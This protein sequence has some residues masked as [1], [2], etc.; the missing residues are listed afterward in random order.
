[1]RCRLHVRNVDLLGSVHFYSS[2]LRNLHLTPSSYPIRHAIF[3]GHLFWIYSYRLHRQ[4]V[5]IEIF[6]ITCQSYAVPSFRTMSSVL[7]STGRPGFGSSLI[8][9]LTHRK[10]LN[11]ILLEHKEHL[12]ILSGIAFRLLLSVD[13]N[14]NNLR[15]LT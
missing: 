12:S 3:A 11:Q 4:V 6:T 10:G 13:R 1:M 7:A 9:S 8:E 2:L 15:C 14:I 5:I